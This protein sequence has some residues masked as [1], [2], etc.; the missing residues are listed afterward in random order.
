M[1][2]LTTSLAAALLLTATGCAE[3]FYDDVNPSQ[4]A[5]NAKAAEAK[6]VLAEPVETPNT[7]AAATSA[8]AAPAPAPK[9][10]TEA[11]ILGYVRAAN[12]SE[13]AMSALAKKRG[14]KGDVKSFAAMLATVIVHTFNYRRDFHIP[15][16]DVVRTEDAR[17]HALATAHV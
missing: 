10:L 7:P 5:Q 3:L 14:A 1:R 6:A 13:V 11:E 17:T 16:A 12:S 9:L 8:A 4:T 2:I 15:A